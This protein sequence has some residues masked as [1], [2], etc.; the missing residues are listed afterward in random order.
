MFLHSKNA[1]E[2]NHVVIESGSMTR[3]MTVATDIESSI[4]YLWSLQVIYL[5]ILEHEYSV[6]LQIIQT[7]ILMLP[8][9]ILDLLEIHG[10]GDQLVVIR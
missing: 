8:D 9:P 3:I 6:P 5:S 7:A 2:S 10:L 4:S 1:K